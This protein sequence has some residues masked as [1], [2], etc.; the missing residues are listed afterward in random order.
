MADYTSNLKIW[1]STGEE[2]PDGYSYIEGEQ[3]VDAWDNFFAYNTQQ[4]IDHLIQLTNDRIESDK[5]STAPASPEPGHLYYDTDTGELQ[6]YDDTTSTW[7]NIFPDEGGSLNDDLVAKDGEIIWDESA[8]W[9]PQGRLENDNITLNAGEG[10][11]G[12]G[13]VALG[14]SFSANVDVTDFITTGIT[15]DG[16][17]NLELDESVIKDG[18]P[19]E[20]D[21]Q[22]FAGGDGA[23]GQVL[24]TDGA[25]AYWDS[26]P[27]TSVSDNASLIES[28][29]SDINFG[30]ELSAQ[31]DGDGSVT[32]DSNALEATIVMSHHSGGT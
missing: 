24:F 12:G 5:D 28:Q 3:P 10:L 32:V 15:E 30:E 27:V 1:G 25:D 7:R 14:G 23:S 17:N 8:G 18:G 29:P 22:E 21:V 11:D 2:Y 16:S 9:I 31:N 26:P 13:S 6:W 19:K 4:D 20:I